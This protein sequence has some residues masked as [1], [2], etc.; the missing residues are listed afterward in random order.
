MN[1]CQQGPGTVPDVVRLCG[2]V[3]SR[4]SVPAPSGA[5]MSEASGV[6]SAWKGAGP[7]SGSAIGIAR[8]LF[9]FRFIQYQASAPERSSLRY[10]RPGH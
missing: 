10:L 4:A 5:L 2:A 9:A 7:H 3:S 6:I 8:G 1:E